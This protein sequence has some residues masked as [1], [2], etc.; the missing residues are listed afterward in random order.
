MAD[1]VRYQPPLERDIG[2]IREYAHLL[3]I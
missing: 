1:N 3:F 2:E